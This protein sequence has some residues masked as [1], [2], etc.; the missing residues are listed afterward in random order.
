[1]TAAD[2]DPDARVDAD[3]QPLLAHLAELRMRV[4][5]A[6]LAVLIAFFPLFYVANELYA[7]VS[8][9]LRAV[10]PEGS[11]MIATEV[12]SPFLTP[13][14]LA[15][16]LAFFLAIPY[17]LHQIWSF[18]SPGLYKHEK[19]LAIPLLVSSVLLFYAGM[20][21]AYYAVFPLV[22]AF[23][24]SVGPEDV[25]IATDINAYLSFVLKLFFAF[26]FAFEIP[27]ATLLLVWSGATDVASLK[28]KRAYVVVGCFVTGML[29]TPPDVISQILLALPMW[30]LY[31]VGIL[32]S[33]VLVRK[34][35][36]DAEARGEDED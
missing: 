13:F 23:L 32:F 36:E 2:D 24:T 8:A 20:A 17:V 26:G 7:F 25:A 14:K 29:L 31:E 21:F 9:P 28:A 3:A 27:V 34:K 11:T 5:R 12:A 10:L 15:F 19:R 30:L 4:L 18:V 22:F 33:A 16:V 35:K 1:V 6:V